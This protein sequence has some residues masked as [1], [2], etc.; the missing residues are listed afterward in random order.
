MTDPIARWGEIASQ[1]MQTQAT[2]R[3]RERAQTNGRIANIAFG[4]A[5]ASLMGDLAQRHMDVAPLHV[6]ASE[7]DTASKYANYA[8]IVLIAALRDVTD[9]LCDSAWADNRAAQTGAAEVTAMKEF[10]QFALTD[11]Q[12]VT[13][14]RQLP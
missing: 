2:P 14:K 5:E 8:L 10:I 4:D 11:R 3:K 9:S 6:R 7:L 12:Y 13:R 1:I